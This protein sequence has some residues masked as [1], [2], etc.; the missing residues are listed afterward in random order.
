MFDIVLTLNSSK[1]RNN[2]IFNFSKLIGSYT[3]IKEAINAVLRLKV[4]CANQQKKI[5]S[6]SIHSDKI[7]EF[8]SR[9]LLIL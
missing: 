9:G 2:V 6:H 3:Y 1:H 8:H 4:F 7:K 5:L